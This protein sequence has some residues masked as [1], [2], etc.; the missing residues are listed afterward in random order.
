LFR[1]RQQ[2][3]PARRR[4]GTEFRGAFESRNRDAHVAALQSAVAGRFESLRDRFVGP[5][6][7]GCPVPDAAVGLVFQHRCKCDVRGG[8]FGEA[9]CGAD[10]RS[11][12]RVTKLHA[13]R[14]GVNQVCRHCGR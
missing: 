4:I 13:R 11:N 5:H 8:T 6:G 14:V 7:G 2:A 10:G 12:Q 9:R 1:C 3:T